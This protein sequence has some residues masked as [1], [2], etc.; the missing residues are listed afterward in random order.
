MADKI[1][2]KLIIVG[3]SALPREI[4]FNRCGSIAKACGAYL[5]ADV[6]HTATFIA[7]GAHSSPFPA[8]DFV[9]F[10]TVKNLRGPNSGI[11]IYRKSIEK[12]VHGSIFPTSQGGA[13]EN[14]MLA[15]FATLLEWQE[16]DIGSYASG[17]IARSRI[18]CSVFQEKGLRVVTGGTDSHIIL[19]DLSD[20]SKTGADLEVAFES[21]HLLLNKNLVP[22]D[23]RSPME[24]SGI[25]IGTANLE[26]LRYNEADTKSLAEFIVG[27]IKDEITNSG[28]I[29]HLI[30]KYH[31]SCQ[32]AK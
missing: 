25:R 13:N 7:A 29:S 30:S 23:R 21:H 11:L 8:C 10:N 12:K 2:P 16:N 28:I 17:I 1:K 24:T 19:I 4:D 9:T 5:H 26:I 15:K 27:I 14:G 22:G 6:S 20:F 3:G 32:W 18:M 31:K